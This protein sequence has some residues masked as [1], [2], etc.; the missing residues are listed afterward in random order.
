MPHGER[1][2]FSLLLLKLDDQQRIGAPWPRHFY[3][4]FSDPVVM[5]LGLGAVLTQIVAFYGTVERWQKRGGRNSGISSACVFSTAVVRSGE[6]GTGWELQQ[7]DEFLALVPAADEGPGGQ[8]VATVTGL[9]VAGGGD[10]RNYV[11]RTD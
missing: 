10:S 1:C 7:H 11:V 2:V 8:Y 3:G 5:R 9:A 6:A 4:I